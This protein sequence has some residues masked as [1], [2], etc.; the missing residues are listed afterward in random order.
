MAMGYAEN[1]MSFLLFPLLFSFQPKFDLKIEPVILGLNSGI[2]IA[3]L[4]GIINVIGVVANLGFSWSTVSSVHIS[5]IHHPSYLAI[6]ILVSIIATWHLKRNGSYSFNSNWVIPYS[7]IAT[8]F[9]LLCFSLAGIL[10]AMILFALFTLVWIKKRVKLS[11]FYFLLIALP[12]LLISIF[13]FTPILNEEVSG[14]WSSAGKVWNNPIKY[15]K[16]KPGYKT[17]NEIRLIMWTVTILEIIDHPMG[18]GTGNV[19]EHLSERL[20]KYGQFDLARKDDKGSIRYNPHNQFLQTTL[21]IG[22]FGL[23]VLLIYLIL[24]ARLALKKQDMILAVL[25]GSLFFNCL[26]ES[27]LQRQSGIIFYSFF[28]S[29]IVVIIGNRSYNSVK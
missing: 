23:T 13:R 27:I 22:I 1:K 9:F 21:E 3:G 5:P 11:L 12:L 16:D 17:G 10:F 19:D 20:Y 18:V 26:F 25:V 28:L 2:L 24:L 4:I 15:V 14:A 8:G 6:F 29:V 7:I